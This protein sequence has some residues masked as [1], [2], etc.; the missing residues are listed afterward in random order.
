MWRVYKCTNLIISFVKNIKGS[1]LLEREKEN[2]HELLWYAYLLQM[3]EV[4]KPKVNNTRE[5][6]LWDTNFYDML[7]SNKRNHKAGSQ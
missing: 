3:R 6:G 1:S 4:I 7:T 5:I 2:I